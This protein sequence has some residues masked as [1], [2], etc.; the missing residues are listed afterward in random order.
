MDAEPVHS[1]FSLHDPYLITYA[2]VQPRSEAE[3]AENVQLASYIW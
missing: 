2:H 1:V 3:L